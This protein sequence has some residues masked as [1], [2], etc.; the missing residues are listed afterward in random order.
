MSLTL[1]ELDALRKETDRMN[2]CPQ[3][4]PFAPQSPV[5]GEEYMRAFLQ[6]A[7][8]RGISSL[9]FGYSSLKGEDVGLLAKNLSLI[10]ELKE[11]NVQNAQAGAVCG[12][13]LLKR[14]GNT[15]VER[16]NVAQNG[17]N[18]DPACTDAV[19]ELIA[20]G[21]LKE[22]TVSDRMAEPFFER[23]A[24][25]L[26][27]SPLEKL[28][29][30]SVGAAYDGEEFGNALA[31]SNL[32]YLDVSLNGKFSQKALIAVARNLPKSRLEFFAAHGIGLNEETAAEMC[33]GLKESKVK[34][35]LLSF[36]SGGFDA[37]RRTAAVIADMFASHE[38]RLEKAVCE[39][40][41][42]Y[43]ENRKPIF[44]AR[45]EQ[46]HRIAFREAY[47]KKVEYAA[48]L[49]LMLADTLA[50][51]FDTG[52]L[53]KVLAVHKAPL[54]AKECL[55][56]TA[57]GK[58]FIENAALAELLPEIFVKNRWKD[59]KEM[60]TAWNAVPEADKWQLDGRRGRPSFQKIKNEVMRAAVTDLLLKNK[61]KGSK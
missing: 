42:W 17:F 56:K 61:G 60:Q 57:D 23:V 35:T 44:N 30:Q 43:D 5:R 24:P 40:R 20:D 9:N 45:T 26:K 46:M 58:T 37:E 25:L 12:L 19:I 55:E 34:E 59:A 41:G 29:C 21:R 47:R 50:Q 10:P 13:E 4:R 36:A 7:A 38:T 32:K 2:A 3:G 15:K 6:A 14:L 31:E 54:S 22:L 48:D 39:L 49:P 53:P 1:D 11:L 51:G 18:G 28:S 8:E 52:L 16:L 33:K 27:V